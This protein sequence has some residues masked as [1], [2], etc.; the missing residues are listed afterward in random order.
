MIKVSVIIPYYNAASVI[1]RCAQSLF[2]Q[3]LAEDIEFIFVDDCSTDN[4]TA[5]LKF[6][7]EKYLNRK[8]QVKFL[9]SPNNQG[10][11]AAR[12]Q[13]LNAANGKYI[14]HCDADDY[15]YPSTY[16]T[17]LS[18]ANRTDADIAICDY[19]YDNKGNTCYHSAKAETAEE[20]VEGL[21]N[22]KIH[23]SLC[24]KL[25]KRNL[26][27]SIPNPF[28]PGLNILEDVALTTR[29]AS[30]AKKVTHIPQPL[31]V[32][33][34]DS[35]SL[36]GTFSNDKIEQMLKNSRVVIEYFE[37]VNP[38]INLDNFKRRIR[39]M[40]LYYCDSSSRKIY[41]KLYPEVSFQKSAPLHDFSL[42]QKAITR[43]IELSLYPLADFLITLR[44]ALHSLKPV[45]Q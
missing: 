16:S 7:L 41:R 17:M 14:I 8:N 36:T 39:S 3:S 31:Y 32:Y 40:T 4:S 9:S 1:E 12:L 13:G 35:A 6:V 29:L 2:N 20:L 30:K 33:I 18:Y 28:T 22:G 45:Q 43:C 38:E 24:N 25:V 19:L 23:G 26:Y 21:L 15:V 37:K 34:C 5:R 44:S 10:V 11:A 42:Y 27:T